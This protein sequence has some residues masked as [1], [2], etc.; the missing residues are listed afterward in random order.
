MWPRSL[1]F[2]GPDR[3]CRH[4]QAAGPIDLLRSTSIDVENNIHWQSSIAS[5]VIIVKS[6]DY[7]FLLDVYL[8]EMAAYG[9]PSHVHPESTIR[10]LQCLSPIT[11]QQAP[12]VA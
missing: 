9:Y 1:G 2:D 12:R 4:S 6:N 10:T 7:L 3:P 8:N 11:A 5:V